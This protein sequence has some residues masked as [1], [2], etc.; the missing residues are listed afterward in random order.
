M[1]KV[2]SYVY[3]ADFLGYKGIFIIAINR[4]PELLKIKGNCILNGLI[5]SN[6][7]FGDRVRVI[8]PK[9]SI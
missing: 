7:D 2:K 6:S 9:N 8:I 5:F 1:E 4:K 3:S